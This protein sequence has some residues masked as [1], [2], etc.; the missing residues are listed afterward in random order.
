M[1]N[2]VKA[3]EQLLKVNALSEDNEDEIE[4]L[5]ELL[6]EDEKTYRNS[7]HTLM[8]S[9]LSSGVR[10]GTILVESNN[11]LDTLGLDEVVVINAFSMKNRIQWKHAVQC[12]FKFHDTIKDKVKKMEEDRELESFKK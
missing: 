3:V 7:I 11:Q 8:E 2:V 10:R 12:F 9:R 4:K 5:I 6:V 1:V